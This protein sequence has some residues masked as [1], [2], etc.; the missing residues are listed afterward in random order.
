MFEALAA[1]ARARLVATRA[2]SA[3]LAAG[4]SREARPRLG[5]VRKFL[6]YAAEDCGRWP[7]LAE[8]D[9][10]AAQLKQL[11]R[12][13]DGRREQPRHLGEFLR[14]Y[15]ATEVVQA[16]KAERPADRVRCLEGELIGE[17]FRAEDDAAFLLE[18]GTERAAD[19]LVLRAGQLDAIV[20][21]GSE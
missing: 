21:Q 4:R 13:R 11:R 2:R 14:R 10:I 6:E 8:R 9:A 12:A 3:S 15:D 20:L 1:A 16:V 5:V 19:G 7:P 17:R 18:Q